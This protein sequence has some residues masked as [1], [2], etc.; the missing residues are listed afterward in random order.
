MM[1]RVVKINTKPES[2]SSVLEKERQGINKGKESANVGS[3]AQ[4]STHDGPKMNE[5]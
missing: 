5:T 1:S 3:G 4:Q 2:T